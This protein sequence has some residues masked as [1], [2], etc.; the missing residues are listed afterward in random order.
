MAGFVDASVKTDLVRGIVESSNQM[1]SAPGKRFPES[2]IGSESA[3]LLVAGRME[4][5]F[6]ALR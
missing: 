2:D 1:S 5:Q 4:L 3:L 6:T